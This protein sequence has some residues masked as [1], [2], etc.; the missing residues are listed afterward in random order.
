MRIRE[1]MVQELELQESQED[2]FFETL[3]EYRQK[4]VWLFNESRANLETA[5]ESQAEELMTELSGILT[6][7]QLDKFDQKFSRRAMMEHNRPTMRRRGGDGQGR[8]QR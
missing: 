5:L 6:P 4:S 2:R 1:M 7:E 3:M 8:G